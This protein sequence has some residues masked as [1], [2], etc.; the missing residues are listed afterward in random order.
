MHNL[1]HLKPLPCI[2]AILAV[3]ALTSFAQ[4]P[5]GVLAASQGGDTPLSNDLQK[6][7]DQL[8]QQYDATTHDLQARIAALE[9]QIQ[10]QKEETEKT[11]QATVSATELA[12]EKAAQNAVLGESDQVGAK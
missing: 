10:K 3:Q 4:Q 12:A 11:K 7:L 8:K 6:Q 9:Q 2:V 5:A 1:R